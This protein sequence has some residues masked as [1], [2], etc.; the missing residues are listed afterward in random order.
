[1][2]AGSVPLP[3]RIANFLLTYRSIPHAATSRTRSELFLGRQLHTRLHLLHPQ[4]QQEV[5]EHQA[6]QKANRDRRTHQQELL[7]GQK[8]MARN[9]R[10]GPRWPPGVIV[11]HLGPLTYS[12]QVHSGTCW[13]CH[14]DQFRGLSDAVEVSLPDSARAEVYWP[15]STTEQSSPER[16][17]AEP[18]HDQ[19][20]AH[21]IRMD[22]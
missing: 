6:V 8:V 1:M 15:S 13:R 4:C 22:S 7:P 9:Y 19:P 11:Q 18:T 10:S 17:D 2:K 20:A 16:T 12:V 14:I 3:H 5:T 21:P